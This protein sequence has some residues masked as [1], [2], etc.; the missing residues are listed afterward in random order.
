M[1][2]FCADNFSIF[3]SFEN[4]ISLR[5][6]SYCDIINL[7]FSK[8]KKFENKMTFELKKWTELQVPNPSEMMKIC[9]KLTFVDLFPL[10]I[11]AESLYE[12]GKTCSLV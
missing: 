4:Y 10:T 11:L 7:A 8:K 3:T 1:M 5:I 12:R 2:E 9:T 6:R